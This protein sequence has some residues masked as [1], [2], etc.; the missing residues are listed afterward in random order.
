L[1]GRARQDAQYHYN[2]LNGDEMQAVILAAGFGKR[3]G[4]FKEN[5]KALL[6]IG[7]KP[8]LDRLLSFLE[9]T[10]GLERVNIRTNGLYYPLFKEWLK[11]S[12]YTGLVELCSNGAQNDRERLGAVGDLENVCAKKRINDDIL[13]VAGDS[14]FDFSIVPFLEYAAEK[15]GDTVAVAEIRDTKALKAGGVVKVTSGSRII[16]FEEKP[17]KPAS[18][19][20]AMPLY[21]VSRQTMAQFKKYLMEGNDKDNLGSF[22]AWSYRRRPLYAFRAEGERH[23]ITDLGTYRRI[24]SIF[25]NRG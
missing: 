3:M 2:T 8:V 23:H 12:E 20:L 5:P 14:I 24:A 9:E 17:V 11:R 4:R 6:E 7:G 16:E 25:E 19:L 22:F 1:N 13:V 21:H 15:D 10:P 18:R